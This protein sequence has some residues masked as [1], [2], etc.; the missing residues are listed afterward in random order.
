[1]EI[2]DAFVWLIYGLGGGA[3]LSASLFIISLPINLFFKV[4]KGDKAQ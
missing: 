2:A 3:L 1:M 4:T